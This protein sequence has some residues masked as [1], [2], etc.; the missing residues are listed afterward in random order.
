MICG[1]NQMPVR[2]ELDATGEDFFNTL[3]SAV[4]KLERKLDRSV[5]YVRL[6][7][8]KDSINGCCLVYLKED[9]VG[10]D[11]EDAREWFSELAPKTRIYA[12]IERDNGDD[13]EDD[14]D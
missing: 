12:I 11:W 6:S 4:K 2:L 9:Q 10:D 3:K 5:D 1:G 8:Q 14:D 13:D 7:P